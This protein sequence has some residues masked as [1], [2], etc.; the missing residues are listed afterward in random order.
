[1]QRTIEICGKELGWER[2]YR[3]R[4]Q[5]LAYLLNLC[6]LYMCA[7]RGA[8]SYHPTLVSYAGLIDRL[9]DN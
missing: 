2:C 7:D 1:M 5:T 6:T 9:C 4:E 8:N 3:P